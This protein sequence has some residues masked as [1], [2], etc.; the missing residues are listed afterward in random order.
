LAQTTLSWI[1]TQLRPPPKG[2]RAPS[3]IFG[4]C[5]LYPNCWMDQGGTWHGGG[6]CSRPHC[7]RWGH[8]SPPQKGQPPNLAHVYCGQTARW[9]KTPLGTEIDLGPGHFVLDGFPAIGER[10]TAAPSFRPMPIV[11]TV[12]RPISATAELLFS[13]WMPKGN[14]KCTTILLFYDLFIVK[15]KCHWATVCK[16]VRPMLSNRCLYCLLVCSM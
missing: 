13:S 11:A 15:Q 6:P 12:T 1:G 9:I 7:A 5:L 8:S 16:T 3:P 14:G 2:G 10:G 4:P